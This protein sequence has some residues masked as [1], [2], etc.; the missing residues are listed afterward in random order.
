MLQWLPLIMLALI[1]IL[2]CFKKEDPNAYKK[3]GVNPG[4]AE[5]KQ[6]R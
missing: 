4:K 1:F 5:P 2:S 3:G 6:N